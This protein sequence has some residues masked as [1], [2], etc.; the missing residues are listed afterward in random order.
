MP[1]GAIEIMFPSAAP[2]A[3]DEAAAAGFDGRLVLETASPGDEQ[4][5]A[6]ANLEYARRVL[7]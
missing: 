6:A 2:A 7:G 3:L 5:D 4:A 1:F